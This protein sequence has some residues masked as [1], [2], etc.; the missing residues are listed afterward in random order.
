MDTRV[1][2]II[3]RRSVRSYTGEPVTD[4]DVVAL[5]Q[6]A[7]A[8]PSASKAKPWHFITF[9]DSNIKQRICDAHQ[10]AK[11]LPGAALGI[12]VC[13]EASISEW[14]VQDCSAAT[15]NIL[16]AAAALGLG[17]VWLG[18]HGCG[19]RGHPQRT[20]SGR[21]STTTCRLD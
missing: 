11:M 16:I 14:W 18:V 9:T 6:A 17:A 3:S 21:R 4:I 13:G 2:T 10:Y 20:R 5:L 7:M 12:A 19:R 1:N 8:A 15:Q